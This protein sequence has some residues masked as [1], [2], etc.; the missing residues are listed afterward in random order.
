MRLA[1]GDLVDWEDGAW[2]SSD[3]FQKSVK[4]VDHDD[5]SIGERSTMLEKL[6][7]IPPVSYT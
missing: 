7:N 2:K 4:T 6:I 5:R 3:R 1:G